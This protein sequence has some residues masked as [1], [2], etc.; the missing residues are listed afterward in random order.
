MFYEL[1]TWDPFGTNPWK[2]STNGDLDSTFIGNLDIYAQITNLVDPGATFKEQTIDTNTTG[3]PTIPSVQTHAHFDADM[4]EVVVEAVEVP[5]ILPDGYGRVFHPQIL[6]HRIIANMIIWQM[7]NTHQTEN[8]DQ[9]YPQT[10][11]LNSCPAL[12]KRHEPLDKFGD[13][14]SDLA[15]FERTTY[16]E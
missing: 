5:N 11:R 1:N 10:L 7:I 13:C 3:D 4:G 6:L 16:D 8:N 2:R 15:N 12:E 14:G 9:G